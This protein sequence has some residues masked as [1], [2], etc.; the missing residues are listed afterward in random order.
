MNNSIARAYLQIFTMLV[1][2]SSLCGFPNWARAEGRCP[3]GQYPIGGQGM[4]GCAPIP[5]GETTEYRSKAKPYFIPT[6]GSIA[7]SSDRIFGMSQHH[8]QDVDATNAALQACREQGGRDCQSM[9]TFKGGCAAAVA[10]D[11]GKGQLYFV[12]ADG[13]VPRQP[14]AGLRA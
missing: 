3:P 4:A 14:S 10:P 12:S 8:K 9:I 13:G 6:W 1:M 5:A 7:V 11:N 2:A